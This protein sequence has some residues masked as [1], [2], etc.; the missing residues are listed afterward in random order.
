MF[1]DGMNSKSFWSSGLFSDFFYSGWINFI[2]QSGAKLVNSFINSVIP[3][4]CIAMFL[5][6]HLIC[7]KMAKQF[8]M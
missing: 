7:A 4:N 1:S 2:V 8:C 6:A 5:L 3:V